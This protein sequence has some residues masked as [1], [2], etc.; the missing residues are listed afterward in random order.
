MPNSA[1]EFHEAAPPPGLPSD[2]L[3]RSQAKWDSQAARMPREPAGPHSTPSR[4]PAMV[5][6]RGETGSAAIA[7]T[8][9]VYGRPFRR[10]SKTPFAGGPIWT[11][12]GPDVLEIV[13]NNA[14]SEA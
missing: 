8:R 6:G 5:G 2:G 4:I 11:R 9:I 10:N 1:I 14:A 3:S 12:V 7:R 13:P